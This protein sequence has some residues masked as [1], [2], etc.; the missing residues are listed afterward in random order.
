[1]IIIIQFQ[2]KIEWQPEFWINVFVVY[3]KIEF[4]I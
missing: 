3:N 1:M 4:G 2:K